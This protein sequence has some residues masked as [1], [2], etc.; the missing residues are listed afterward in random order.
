[1]FPRRSPLARLH[2]PPFSRTRPHLLPSPAQPPRVD[3][4][5]RPRLSPV[6]PSSFPPAPMRSGLPLPC[7]AALPFR[8]R[9]VAQILLSA[10]AG[11][12]RIRQSAQEK[13]T[14]LFP[15]NV[16]Y[17]LLRRKENPVARR[18]PQKTGLP[19]FAPAQ[20]DEALKRPPSS[21]A[22]QASPPFFPEGAASGVSDA[23]PSPPDRMLPI[24]ARRALLTAHPADGTFK[25]KPL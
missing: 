3:S 1:M 9:R 16:Y 8:S 23:L 10:P 19:P 18:C 17:F 14:C 24:Q 20:P 25:R 13:E 5:P 11:P 15:Q 4:F 22:S 21:N 2:R 12:A 6:D 7:C